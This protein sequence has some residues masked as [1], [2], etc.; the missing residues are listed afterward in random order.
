MT[1]IPFHNTK[2]IE[3]ICMR[4][5]AMVNR[6]VQAHRSECRYRVTALK[7]E[8]SFVLFKAARRVTLKK[9]YMSFE[10]DR[11][12]VF[13]GKISPWRGYFRW[14][15]AFYTLSRL[16]HGYLP[17]RKNYF[18]QCV[19]LHF[20]CYRSQCWS[21]EKYFAKDDNVD[22]QPNTLGLIS[23]RTCGMIWKTWLRGQKSTFLDSVYLFI[24][25]RVVGKDICQ[26]DK[27]HIN[28]ARLMTESSLMQYN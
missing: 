27:K 24:F 11:T 8:L 21:A 1:L 7:M 10:K 25:C 17:K 2:S 12:P 13:I 28:E 18:T 26:H 3:Y 14:W 5:V 9:E 23:Y 16:L 6:W 22:W 19:F 4:N 20:I 15:S